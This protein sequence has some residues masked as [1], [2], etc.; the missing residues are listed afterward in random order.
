[1]E[2]SQFFAHA[3]GSAELETN[4][5]SIPAAA[6]DLAGEDFF[7]QFDLAKGKS[8]GVQQPGRTGGRF[9]DGVRRVSIPE[10]LA[11]GGVNAEHGADRLQVVDVVAQTLR[12]KHEVRLQLRVERGQRVAHG[13]PDRVVRVFAGEEFGGRFVAAVRSLGEFPLPRVVHASPFRE[14]GIFGAAQRHVINLR[15]DP[16]IGL[17][18]QGKPLRIL[19]GRREHRAE[20]DA[21]RRIVRESQERAATGE[22]HVVE[23]G[24][25]EE[26]GRHGRD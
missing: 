8:G 6:V 17:T 16:L 18:A 25:E 5:R 14:R 11:R 10:H 24:R 26:R 15:R 21:P 22:R 9:A 12:R 19:D 4:L 3:I 13:L 23:V 2:G 20:H 1:M 7:R